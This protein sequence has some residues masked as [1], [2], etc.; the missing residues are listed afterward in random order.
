MGNII[1]KLINNGNNCCI[2]TVDVIISQ[3]RSV[4]HNSCDGCTPLAKAK[5]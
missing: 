4:E 5:Q 2:P 1:D 3:G